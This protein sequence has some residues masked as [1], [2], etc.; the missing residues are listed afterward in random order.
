MKLSEKR[1]P[2]FDAP[3]SYEAYAEKGATTEQNRDGQ[4][5]RNAL[6]DEDARSQNAASA[7]TYEETLDAVITCIGAQNSLR[8][9]L[10]KTLAFCETPHDFTEVEDFIAASDEVVYSH[11]IQTPFELIGMLVRAGGLDETPLDAAGDPLSSET[12]DAL[13][14]DEQDD[15]IATYRIETTAAGRATVE[16]LAPARRLEAQLAQDP[17]RADTFWALIEFCETPRTF[18]EIKEYFDATPG[19]AHDVVAH[20]HQLAPDFY[21]DKL[22]KAGALVWRGAWVATDAGKSLLEA[23]KASC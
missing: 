5:A 15:L 9:I 21:V 8:E 2:K 1:F 22:D 17:H 11:V 13:S 3:A 23:H 19:F 12:L 14:R 16:L 18:P 7:R 6:S 10:Y 4:S 20:S